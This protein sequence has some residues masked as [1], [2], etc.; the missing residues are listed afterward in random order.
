MSAGRRIT[1]EE[2]EATL[3]QQDWDAAWDYWG[4]LF[5]AGQS[6]LDWLDAME[7][8]AL[9][10][11]RGGQLLA[12]QVVGGIGHNRYTTGASLDVEALRRGLLWIVAALRQE[13]SATGMQM[14]VWDMAFSVLKAC[15]TRRLR[16]FCPNQD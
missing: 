4:A 16:P 13:L 14:L 1:R 11:A 7:A 6:T 5:E 12:Q 9:P 15:E 10:Y 8:A 3:C 2:A